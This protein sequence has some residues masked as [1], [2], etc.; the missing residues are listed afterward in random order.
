MPT[1]LRPTT[2]LVAVAW[3]T[4]LFDTPIVSTTLPKTSTDQTIS[5]AATGFVVVSAVGG[6]PNWYM[7]MRNPV[8]SVDCWA[9]NPQSGK[10]PWGRANNLAETIVAA[11]YDVPSI[12][13]PLTLPGGFPPARVLTAYPLGEP[14]R[15]RDDQA[16]Y[17]RY[18]L[19]LALMWRA[20]G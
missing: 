19:P 3:L 7:P 2:D 17:A 11:C 14:Q 13:R 5:W 16:S 12:S 18:N 4:S 9:V 20:E 10:P 15:V 8:V 6:T 1:L